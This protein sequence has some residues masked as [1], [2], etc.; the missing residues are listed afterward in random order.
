MCGEVTFEGDEW[1]GVS[2]SAKNLIQG[3]QNFSFYWK[4]LMRMLWGN[5]FAYRIVPVTGNP[6]N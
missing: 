4:V 1:N 2:H 3:I 5:S 6:T